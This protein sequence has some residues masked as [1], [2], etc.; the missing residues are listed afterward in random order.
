[1]ILFLFFRRINTIKEIEFSTGIN[2]HNR[3]QDGV[4]IFHDNKLLKHNRSNSPCHNGIVCVIKISDVFDDIFYTEAEYLKSREFL[5]LENFLVKNI[6]YYFLA[7]IKDNN[8][9]QIE[10]LFQRVGYDNLTLSEPSNNEPYISQRFR[11]SPL[12]V[13][14]EICKKFRKLLSMARPQ[15]LV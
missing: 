14:C 15:D 13:Q 3:E 11:Y 12:V 1:M 6:E 9:I 8:S 4:M 5:A 2:V 10:S 7:E